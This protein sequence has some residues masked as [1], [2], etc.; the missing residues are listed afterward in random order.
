MA[1]PMGARMMSGNTRLHE[2]LEQELADFE[3]KE[4]AYE[5]NFGYQGIVSTIDALTT[6]H[7]V[8][9]F[10]SEAHACLIDGKRLH[11]GQSFH[12]KHNDIESCEKAL[13]RATEI[14]NKTGGGIL[15][16]TEG[17]FGMTGPVLR[18]E[19]VF[20]GIGACVLAW[21][22][23]LYNVQHKIEEKV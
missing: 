18:G 9:V 8:I 12:F 19:G 23:V 1:Y 16:I 22:V 2:R 17:V 4:A 7:D 14:V 11:L 5:F 3:R 21:N 13:K 15:L 20:R 6:R 10:D